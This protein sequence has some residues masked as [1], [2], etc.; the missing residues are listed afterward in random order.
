MDMENIYH[1]QYTF[2]LGLKTLFHLKNHRVFL[3]CRICNQLYG[4]VLQ[5]L[6]PSAGQKIL[7]T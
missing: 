5:N 4:A 6:N 2:P 1:C 3:A 7:Q